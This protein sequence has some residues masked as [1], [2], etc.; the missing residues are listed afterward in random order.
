M[1]KN[2]ICALTILC[3]TKVGFSGTIPSAYWNGVLVEYMD[4]HAAVGVNDVTGRTTAYS[5]FDQLG[6][7][8]VDSFNVLNFAV[9]RLPNSSTFLAEVS[10]LG[11]NKIVAY[12]EPVIY[13]TLDSQVHPNDE[14]YTGTAPPHKPL[15]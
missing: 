15:F 1:S 13:G 14:F 12:A 9:I 5:L 8:V 2:I 7:V 11:Q 6:Y 3:L 4:L 10:T